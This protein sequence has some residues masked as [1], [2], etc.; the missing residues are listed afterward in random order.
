MKADQDQT[1]GRLVLEY[2]VA[3][4]KPGSY[5]LTPLNFF[6]CHPVGV[7]VESKHEM[8]VLLMYLSLYLLDPSRATYILSE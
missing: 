6:T 7:E 2:F 1:S 5:S 4:T 8:L 3:N